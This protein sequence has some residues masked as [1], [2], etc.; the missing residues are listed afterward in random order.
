[1]FQSLYALHTCTYELSDNNIIRMFCCTYNWDAVKQEAKDNSSPVALFTTTVMKRHLTNP[2]RVNSV[3]FSTTSGTL[4]PP[5][6][7]SNDRARVLPQGARHAQ[8]LADRWVRPKQRG[9]FDHVSWLAHI[10]VTVMF[11]RGDRLFL[12]E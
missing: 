6:E 10:T 8:E 1:M 7:I 2:T 5:S 4:P 11:R 9:V 12:K 3:K